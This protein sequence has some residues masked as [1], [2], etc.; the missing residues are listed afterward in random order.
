[1]QLQNRIRMV[2]CLRTDHRWPFFTGGDTTLKLAN[3]IQTIFG[4]ES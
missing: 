2:L 3:S 4:P 1:M